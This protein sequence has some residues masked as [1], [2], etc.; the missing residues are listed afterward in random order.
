MLHPQLLAQSP[1]CDTLSKCLLTEGQREGTSKERVGKEGEK[2][3][4]R[5]G[6]PALSPGWPAFPPRPEL[7]IH[8]SYGP[9]LQ[10]LW[11]KDPV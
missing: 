5:I 1:A 10:G 4:N 7:R 6:R 9:N 2:E 8:P 11:Q 3:E